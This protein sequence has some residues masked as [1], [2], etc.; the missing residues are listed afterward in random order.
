MAGS[1]ARQVARIYRQFVKEFTEQFPGCNLRPIIEGH[2]ADGTDFVFSI[3]VADAEFE[4]AVEVTSRLGAK[5]FTEYGV[6]F[7]V[8]PQVM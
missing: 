3:A 1:P 6:N 5:Y 2:E 4:K 7:L 8:V